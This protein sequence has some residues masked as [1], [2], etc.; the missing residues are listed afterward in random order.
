MKVLGRRW[1][2]TPGGG[3]KTGR[4][5]RHE[6]WRSGGCSSRALASAVVEGEV[7][8]FGGWWVRWGVGLC[9]GWRLVV[10][11]FRGG[12]CWFYGFWRLV[13]DGSC[14]GLFFF[15]GTGKHNWM[16]TFLDQVEKMTETTLWWRKHDGEGFFFFFLVVIFSSS[17]LTAGCF[18][19]DRSMFALIPKLTQETRTKLKQRKNKEYDLRVSI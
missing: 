14:V 8:G 9:S 5:R 18:R 2:P 6:A 19:S 7:L 15:F 12:G 13:S 11:G 1:R 16:A 17:G 4:Q 3:V 10:V